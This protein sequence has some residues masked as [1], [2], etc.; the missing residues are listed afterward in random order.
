M[1]SPR[2]SSPA[3][4]SP[5]TPS[6]AA[7]PDLRTKIGQML[8]VGFRGLRAEPDSQVMRD[9]VDLGLGG[10]LLFDV[11]R[12]TGSL[13]R[14]VESPDQLR[15]LV[16]GLQAAAT[17]TSLGVPLLV[18]T[19]QEGGR[20]ARLGPH[21]GFP[22]TESAA[23]LGARGDPAYT[24]ARA[25]A[26]AETLAD[27]GI[28]LNLAPVVDLDLNPDNP[29]IGAL[30]RSFSADPNVVVSQAL[31]FI[32]GHRR[33][34][35]RTTLKHF[36]GQG[37]ATGDTHEGVVDVTGVWTE[38]EL[39]P[40]ARISAKGQADAILTAHVFNAQ[41]DR[42]YP[43]T[44]SRATIDGILR[45]RLGYDGVV[46]S[47]DMQMGAITDAFGYDEAIALAI[48]AGVDILT[49]ANQQVFEEGIVA[50]TVDI[51]AGQVERGR[52]SEERINTSWERI[53]RFK[54]ALLPV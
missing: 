34:G 12:P 35:V 11:D 10:V 22:R 47:D 32:A 45:G 29:A 5:A 14:N 4:P 28:N 48:N 42:R 7:G 46:L 44:L 37:S 9:I 27:V 16:A 52:I 26:M 53:R 13:V 6:P 33:L 49:I 20:V 15:A 38:I 54:A 51:I 23:E 30:D 17:A 3:T 43:A 31:A 18:A 8:L 39:E 2:P 19:D 1:P 41:L 36:P 21:H 24:E 50:K 25:E 40:F